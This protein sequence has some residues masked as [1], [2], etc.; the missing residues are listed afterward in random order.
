VSK[1]GLSREEF[2]AEQAYLRRVAYRI[3]GTGRDT[4]EAVQE[5]WLRLNEGGEK[6]I[7]NRRAWLT[8]VVARICLD[9]LRRRRTRNE[10][11]LGPEHAELPQ[12]NDDTD[13]PESS[14]MFADSVSLAL[15]IVL[16]RLEPHERLAFVLHDT[17]GMSFEEIAPI[18][19]RSPAAARQVASRARKRVQGEPA[20]DG[21]ERHRRK[22]LIENFRVAAHQGDL[23]RLISLLDPDAELRVDPQMLPDGAPTL[24]RGAARVARQA[25]LGKGRRAQ[26]AI[27]DGDIGIIVGA[28]N[29]LGLAL[30]FDV[31][32][33]IKGIELIA[34]PERL[35]ALEISLLDDGDLKISTGVC[36]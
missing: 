30:T 25:L 33:K 35:R 16:D 23:Q 1:C 29:R 21:R 9:M 26:L 4:D 7:G 24:I 22:D 3:L 18:I 27:V 11:P 28:D 17:F 2:E 10:E 6:N 15:L 14:A 8:K 5:A 20:V 13:N 32:T 19:D 36:Q 34:S 31:G 12:P